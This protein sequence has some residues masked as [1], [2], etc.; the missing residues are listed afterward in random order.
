MCIRDSLVPDLAMV[1]RLLMS[2]FL[3]MPMPE[4][5]MV[6]VE[7]VLSGTILMKKFG[8]ASQTKGHDGTERNSTSNKVELTQKYQEANYSI[9]NR[10]NR[11][12]CQGNCQ[13]IQRDKLKLKGTSGKNWPILAPTES[14]RTIYS[15]IP[16]WSSWL[17]TYFNK[18]R[19]T[20]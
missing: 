17:S 3:V 16:P 5:S 7:L 11:F 9:R 4:S 10:R 18:E 8:W 20:F 13:G 1:P 14:Q 15:E 6:K 2:S 12:E 19:K